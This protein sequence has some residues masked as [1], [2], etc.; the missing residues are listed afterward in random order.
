MTNRLQRSVPLTVLLLTGVVFL[1]DILTPL[2]GTAWVL[3]LPVILA[4]VWLHNLKD[5]GYLPRQILIA[6]ALC[7]ILVVVGLF[8][9]HPD[10]WTWRVLRNRGMVLI[11]L[12][13][14]T[15]SAIIIYRRSFQLAEAMKTLQQEIARHTQ[16]SQLLEKAEERLRLAVEGAGMGT[17]DVNMQT[18]T[19]VWSRNH[20][21]MLGYEN[22]TE[23]QATID[24]WRSCV[25]PNDQ[26]RIQE[27]RE[28]ALKHRSLYSVEYRIRRADNGEISCLAV[29]GRFFHDQRGEAVRFLGVSFDITRRKELEREV[30]EITAREKQ[31]IGQ[32][33]HDGVGQELTGLGLMAQT[34]SLRLLESSSEKPIAVRLVAGLNQ[35]H[36]QIRALARGLVPVDM[37]EKVCRPRWMTW[38]PRRVSSRA[39]LSNSPARIGS[40]CRTTPRRS[41]CTAL[42]R[43]R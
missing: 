12:W 32:E 17:F 4:P 2:G 16:T 15:I 1:V 27:A 9:T 21:R 11:A 30:L 26:D 22:V 14:T 33:L 5:T 13:L 3:Y 43:K 19:A 6:S 28:Q 41:N 36:Q 24:M 20:L 29:F 18:R 35:L 39:F 8:L 10:A 38:P 34:L 7:S 37:E 23:G 31:H 42:P 40:S 25:H